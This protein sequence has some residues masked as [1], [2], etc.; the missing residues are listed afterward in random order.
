MKVQIVSIG[1]EVV[2]GVVPDTNA[3]YLSLRLEELGA[4]VIGHRAVR[5]RLSDAVE[6][7]RA[8]AEAADVVVVTGGLGPTPDDITRE[9][10]CE[11]LG[12]E[13]VRNERALELLT[14][15]FRQRGRTPSQNNLRQ[16]M[17]PSRTELLANHSGTACGFVARSAEARL[18][19]LPGVP[20][21]M[22][23][24]FREEVAP[25]LREL[26][27]E[28]AVA[29]RLI[30]LMGVPESEVSARLEDVMIRGSNPEVG[31][32]AKTGFIQV[33]IVAR[34]E[35]MQQAE[36][37]VREVVEKVRERFGRQVAS[38]TGEEPH[39]VV[40]RMLIE[41]GRTLAV[42][43][44]CTGGLIADM[45]TGVPGI[46]AALLEALVCYG[47]ASKVNRLRVPAEQIEAHG[48]VSAEVAAAM[49][50]GVRE[51]AGADIGLSVTGIA[52]PSG[53]VPAAPGRKA[54]PVG[55][56]YLALA[57]ENGIVTMERVFPGDRAQV[58]RRAAL[59]ALDG[60][61]LRLSEPRD[62]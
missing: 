59:A 19:F 30:S 35:R 6:A 1:D 57:D 20:A 14:E 53:G 21:E 58:R 16:T 62:G 41:R 46:S 15:F 17:L 22:A 39:Q 5:D 38:E 31:T 54:K 36:D 37:R 42:A 40:A 23:S 3:S 47:N 61:R 49:A 9:A 18:F 24:M 34:A 7:L 33:R 8:A 29:T 25:R 4:E 55:L 32:L 43:E 56:V 50:S 2:S 13:P 51:T 45:L 52:G 12:V 44:S 60:V 26:I 28:S 11:L 48:A 10:A 27:G